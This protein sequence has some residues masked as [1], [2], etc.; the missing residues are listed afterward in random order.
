MKLKEL[1]GFPKTL[2][3]KK[4]LPVYKAF[5]IT[6][7]EEYMDIKVDVDLL[8]L[9]EEAAVRSMINELSLEE[10]PYVKGRT[11]SFAVIEIEKESLDSI[12][13]VDH[14]EIFFKDEII[15]ITL[16]DKIYQINVYDK[17][18]EDVSIEIDANTEIK[19]VSNIKLVKV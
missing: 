5:I 8:A 6:D 12:D 10:I 19:L 7:P 11:I 13:L 3:K 9:T 16:K 14:E 15:S 4:S 1:E 18:L 2:L 17:I